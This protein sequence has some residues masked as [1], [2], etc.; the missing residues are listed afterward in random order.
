VE[1]PKKNVTLRDIDLLRLSA[2]DR[3]AP[4]SEARPLSQ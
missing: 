2:F 1:N 3:F 4:K